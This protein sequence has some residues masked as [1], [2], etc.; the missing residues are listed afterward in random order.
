MIK[1]EDIKNI[2]NSMYELFQ[3]EL[4]INTDE[5]TKLLN[6]NN[7][8]VDIEDI[9]L[10]I[11]SFQSI[12]GASR[13]IGFKPVENIT[14]K[15][16]TLLKGVKK[17]CSNAECIER[18]NQNLLD[19]NIVLSFIAE[20][21]KIEIANDVE[22][23]SKRINEQIANIDIT[24]NSL[25]E[26]K[27]EPVIINQETSIQEYSDTSMIDLFLIEVE[28]NC[29]VLE[30]KLIDAEDNNSGD[31]IEP[32]MR[33]SHSIKGAARIVGLDIPVNLAHNMEEIL[34]KA[35]NGKLFLDSNSIDELLKSTDIF[36]RLIGMSPELVSNW[37]LDQEDEI[38]LI[39]EN[40]VNISI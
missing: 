28:N 13:I 37:F 18:I 30:E 15:I 25:N 17:D 11:V 20:K 21:S 6:K 19:S 10:M 36:K 3:S 29:R 1:S 8:V 32:L 14:E 12:E 23:I 33:A 7:G 38:A 5:V 22:N 27:E 35:M 39:N 34:D 4:R 40:L 26:I 9:D 16:S 2:D 24:L 31:M